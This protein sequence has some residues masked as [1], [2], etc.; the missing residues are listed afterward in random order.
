MA[1]AAQACNDAVK[2]DLASRLTPEVVM[3]G[4]DLCKFGDPATC[5]WILQSGTLLIGHRA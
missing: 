1:A 4:H 3:P 5:L 2:D